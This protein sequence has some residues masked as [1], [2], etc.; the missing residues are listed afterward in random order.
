MHITRRN[1]LQTSAS[2][3]LLTE[4]ALNADAAAAAD[5]QSVLEPEPKSQFRETRDF[6]DGW[7]FAQV[8]AGKE[9]REPVTNAES[10][11]ARKPFAPFIPE[12]LEEPQDVRLPHDWGIYGPFDTDPKTWGG[13]GKL[14]WRGVG[15]YV[16]IF[17]LTEEEAKKR[18]VFDFGGCMAFPEVYL[19]AG[20]IGGWDYGYMSFQV[21]ATKMLKVGENV[22]FVRC[23][24]RRHG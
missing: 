10:P 12:P 21:D 15:W 23:D 2:A 17:N 13:Q 24:T 16:K 8:P 14:P 22:L 4:L 7:K 20:Y 6:N 5:F 19:N 11:D 1:F 3:A 18:V 9:R